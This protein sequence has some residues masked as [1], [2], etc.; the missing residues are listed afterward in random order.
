MMADIH[1]FDTSGEAKDAAMANTT[2]LV[3]QASSLVEVH[4]LVRAKVAESPE[5]LAQ[6]VVEYVKE[7]HNMVV[8]A[9]EIQAIAVYFAGRDSVFQYDEM[10]DIGQALLRMDE[11]GNGSVEKNEAL[12]LLYTTKA[13][14]INGDG[15]ID[16]GERGALISVVMSV[17]ITNGAFAYLKDIATR[18][19]GEEKDFDPDEVKDLTEAI[20]ITAQCDG[21]DIL[22]PDEAQQLHT[23]AKGFDVDYAIKPGLTVESA[24]L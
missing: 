5:D 20:R 4:E 12:Q 6:Q 22:D 7:E 23:L 24:N 13:F 3:A 16:D 19:A 11:N 21:N 9:E 14:D 8:E 2:S 10:I 15:E 17:K 18:F 1:N